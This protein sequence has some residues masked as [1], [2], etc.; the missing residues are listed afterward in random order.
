MKHIDRLTIILAG[1]LVLILLISAVSYLI[2]GNRME[3][4]VIFFPTHQTLEMQGESRIL[5]RKRTRELEIELLVKEI[6]LG[7]FGID[8]TPVIPEDSRIRSI[9]LRDDTLYLDFSIDIVFPEASSSLSLEESM[10]YITRSVQFNF[11]DV[12][13]IIYTVNGNQL[14]VS[15]AIMTE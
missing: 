5:P 9:M 8:Y 15:S 4:Q 7:P 13:K 1:S 2:W 3:Q 14:K 6:I 11:P 10:E 12:K